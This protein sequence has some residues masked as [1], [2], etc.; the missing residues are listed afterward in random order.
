M[1]P[2]LDAWSVL[3]L[4]RQGFALYLDLSSIEITYEGKEKRSCGVMKC[5]V[6]LMPYSLH[7]TQKKK[8]SSLLFNEFTSD[9]V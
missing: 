4:Y 2:H 3:D 6:F 5:G 1:V 9:L 7:H 8:S